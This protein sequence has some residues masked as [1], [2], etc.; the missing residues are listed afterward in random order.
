MLPASPDL[1]AREP[2]QRRADIAITFPFGEH[3]DDSYYRQ[4]YSL[5]PW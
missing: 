1:L 4:N 2:E 3:S 5:H